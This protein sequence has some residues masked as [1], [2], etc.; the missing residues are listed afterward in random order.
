M[1]SWFFSF[2]FS[3]LGPLV[4]HPLFYFFPRLFYGQDV[5]HSDLQKCVLLPCCLDRINR[6]FKI[7]LCHGYGTLCKARAGNSIVRVAFHTN[8][9]PTQIL[10]L[11]FCIV[12]ACI[13][14]QRVQCP[15]STSSES[16]W[17]SIVFPNYS[18]VVF[19]IF[20]S[21]HYHISG[22]SNARIALPVLVINIW[23]HFRTTSR[24]RHL[25]TN[26][27]RE[28]CL[29]Q[30]HTSRFTFIPVFLD[31]DFHRTCSIFAVCKS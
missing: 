18:H 30:R 25:P 19:N 26:L 10:N 12:S 23:I 9:C 4:V 5:Q 3:Q 11:F 16:A 1:K 14:F 31:S 15:L 24:F 2:L 17:S 7:H 29:Y 20:S 22:G 27:R 21:A 8:W 28:F 6:R 13:A